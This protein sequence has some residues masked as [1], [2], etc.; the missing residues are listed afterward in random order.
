M[1]GLENAIDDHPVPGKDPSGQVVFQLNV[2][3]LRLLASPELLGRLLHSYLLGI[4]E[5]GLGQN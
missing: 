4:Y 2:Q 3:S 1:V 5:L